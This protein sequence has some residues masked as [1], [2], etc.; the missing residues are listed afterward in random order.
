MWHAHALL[1]SKH[2]V[3]ILYPVSF[4]QG[5]YE[6]HTS[7]CADNLDKELVE[8]NLKFQIAWPRM[9]PYGKLKKMVA[10]KY[11]Y[12]HNVEDF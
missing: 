9:D 7:Q 5:M 6:L 3:G 12:G 8:Y 11:A 2:K 10:A 4:S 1:S